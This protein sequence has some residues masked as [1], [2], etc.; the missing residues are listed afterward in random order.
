MARQVVKGAAGLW[1][2]VSEFAA[3]DNHQNELL[4]CFIADNGII[5]PRRGM[6]QM[7]GYLQSR[8]A[9]YSLSNSPISMFVYGSTLF[10]F[11]YQ[12]DD[13]NLAPLYRDNG[14]GWTAVDLLGPGTSALLVESVGINNE[15]SFLQNMYIP[16]KNRGLYVLDSATGVGRSAGFS[17]P[18]P[19]ET[20]T[21]NVD[22]TI[23]PPAAGGIATGA[24]AW[25]SNT[26][27]RVAYRVLWGLKDAHEQVVLGPPSAR[28]VY[29][30]A[31]DATGANASIY[32][33]VPVV[34]ESS[35]NTF[36]QVYR[37]KSVDT[38]VVDTAPSDDLY[39]VY[40]GMGVSSWVNGTPG[41]TA[42]ATK[43]NLSTTVTVYKVAHG[44][45]VN[46]QIKIAFDAADTGANE[47]LDGTYRVTSVAADSFTYI[48]GKNNAS[49]SLYTTTASFSV[50]PKTFPFYDYSPDNL[51]TNPLYTNPL[52]GDG[53]GA[54]REKPPQCGTM[55]LWKERLW[56]GDT[57][58]PTRLQMTLTG[59]FLGVGAAGSNDGLRANDTI[60]IGGVTFTAKAA[61][62]TATEFLLNT[63]GATPSINIDQT[64]RALVTAAHR[65]GLSVYYISGDQ[66]YPG[67]IMIE[68]T[69]ATVS[70][71]S[72]WIPFKIAGSTY[73]AED[74]HRKNRL[75]FSNSRMPEAVPALQYI[76]VGSADKSI[77]RVSAQKDMLFVF[78]E[79]GVY[80]ISGDYPF[81]LDLLDG[82]TVPLAANTIISG[83]S[84]IY[85]VFN[86]GVCRINSSGINIISAP[87]ANVFRDLNVTSAYAAYPNFALLDELD[88]RY[89]VS[90]VAPDPVTYTQN[91][92]LWYVFNL[93]TK[94]WSRYS[95][96]P[97]SATSTELGARCDLGNIAGGIMLKRAD[98]SCAS[99]VFTSV[100]GGTQ[101]YFK[102]L[103]FDPTSDVRLENV[104]TKRF[105]YADGGYTYSTK[106]CSAFSTASGIDTVTVATAWTDPVV[107]DI[108]YYTTGTS[109]IFTSAFY[110][111]LI[112]AINAAGTVFTCQNLA[113][114]VSDGSVVPAS[115]K[116]LRL[117]RGYKSGQ[118]TISVTQR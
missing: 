68:G 4:N 10:S 41:A 93:R 103:R 111:G 5:E 43:A 46:C 57:T 106:T 81:R 12:D 88:G 66:D 89:M 110:Y 22:P 67:K 84:A 61:P 51:L 80:T 1:T 50:I 15:V 24:W 115:T 9:A 116:T 95:F 11:S 34:A 16:V 42:K 92:P 90:V 30:R 117:L 70:R 36:Y 78:K 96:S 72:A 55:A 8:G 113:S 104:F 71:P 7:N 54:S 73:S 17:T 23:A 20:L 64:A 83:D 21:V 29:S 33:D 99:I 86:S 27:G 25:A 56:F 6:L 58:Q 62:A 59:V 52:D 19:P 3:P 13:L 100:G 87:V 39:Q 102:E 98:A 49:G 74:P 18:A 28:T 85:G 45:R 76:D 48:D 105:M 53:L 82:N 101:D 109:L 69:T 94:S 112:T 14:T 91:N 97:G 107:G 47:L 63:A 114:Q 60:T 40:E 35:S 37:S 75:Y 108:I 26:K 44:L 31:T 32:G 77:L 118:P 79:D 2:S 65:Y 38:T